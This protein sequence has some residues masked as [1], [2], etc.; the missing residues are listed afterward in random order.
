MQIS[1]KL[2]F[3]CTNQNQIRIQRPRLRRKTL[4]RMNTSNNSNNNNIIIVIILLLLIVKLTFLDRILVPGVDKPIYAKFQP[5]STT[6][7][8]LRP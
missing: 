2:D 1:P 5:R 7:S 8:I 3:S 6:G 4:F